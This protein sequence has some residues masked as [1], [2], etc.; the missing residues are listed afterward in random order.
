MVN[1]LIN[2]LLVGAAYISIHFL[3]YIVARR[4]HL[5]PRTERAIFL[6]HFVSF[7]LFLAVV[8]TLAMLSKS[9]PGVAELLGAASMHGIYSLTFLELWSLSQGG[10]SIQVLSY[11]SKSRS[12]H[13]EQMSGQLSEI[14]SDKLTSRLQSLR[15]LRLIRFKE[16]SVSLTYHGRYITAALL[17]LR[18]WVN[19]NNAG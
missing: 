15:S 1:P 11:F 5:S 16:D 18:S 12:C 4:C 2:M 14:G 6:F 8:A 13:A 10:Y 3:T 9:H 7:L 17:A 19:I